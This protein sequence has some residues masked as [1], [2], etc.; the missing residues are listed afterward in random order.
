MATSVFRPRSGDSAPDACGGSS[1][2]GP[3]VGCRE[4]SKAAIVRHALRLGGRVH[5]AERSVT[6]AVEEQMTLPSALEG[7]GRSAPTASVPSRLRTRSAL[8][9]ILVS[10]VCIGLVARQVDLAQSV[11]SLARLNG[12]LLFLPL[13]VFLVAI[14]LR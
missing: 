13:A 4:L 10:V 14:P 6:E 12:Y 2:D 5:P 8:L 11:Q 9:G 7:S 3:R 1:H